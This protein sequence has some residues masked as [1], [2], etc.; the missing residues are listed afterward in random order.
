M[1]ALVALAGLL[2]ASTATAQKPTAATVDK[3]NQEPC[4]VAGQVVRL[5]EGTPLRKANVQLFNLDQE[6]TSMAA[7]TAEDGKF[8]LDKVMPGR[9]RL[10]VTRNGYVP[11]EFG[12]RKSSDPPANLSLR[13]GQKM[14]DLF[15][16]LTPAAASGGHGQD[17]DGD[18]MP[19]VHI[20]VF[21]LTHYNG[22]LSVAAAGE[23]STND[24]GEYRVYNLAPG[25]YFIAAA[26]EP[27]SSFVNGRRVMTG[28][29]SLNP[30]YLPTYYP[31]T[32][33]PQKA[34]SI[35]LKAGEELTSIDVILRPSRGVKVK[36][37][38]YNATGKTLGG[39]N[40]RLALKDSE[41]DYFQT[42]E[43]YASQTDGSFEIPNVPPG[44]YSATAYSFIEGKTYAAKQSIDVGQVD[45]EG[46]NLTIST[47]QQVAGRLVWDGPPEASSGSFQIFLQSVDL[48]MPGG[49]AT[50][51]ADGSF[52]INNIADGEAHVF[53]GG[54][55]KNS[56][57][58]S[59]R[60][61]SS[62]STSRE[63]N[64]TPG[65]NASLEV[66]LSSHGGHITGIVTDS[67]GL[68]ASS[69]W[70]VLVPDALN[71]N[72]YWLYKSVNTD[73]NG[74]FEFRGIV[75][76][77][78]ELFSWD[79]VD[80]GA[81]EDPAFLKAYDDTRQGEDVT[82]REGET[83]VLNITTIHTAQQDQP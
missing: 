62:E 2:L 82:I 49:H 28:D 54:M 58:K 35:G 37:R 33:D 13:P 10:M 64:I 6:G 5:G 20:T 29:N 70:V 63:V 78:Y 50:P 59:V 30:G 36:G 23:T 69:V 38:V 74:N 83:K 18:P 66:T 9:Y 46:L 4:V 21:Q 79:Q 55:G 22:E 39:A 71:R 53:V 19:W 43:G 68:P 81:W 16:R 65:V 48:P 31:N 3:T 44:A 17:E 47:G 7:R 77:Q 12:Q 24:L 51:A 26:Y 60:Y 80:Q 67:D 75:P 52:V 11:Q 73:Q 72:K 14:T 41:R 56:F 8:R 42:H 61:G 32:D 40:V 76:G 57:I 45:V 1:K 27:G 25:R 34:G 15:F